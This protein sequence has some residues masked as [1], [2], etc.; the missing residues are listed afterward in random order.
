MGVLKVYR[1]QLIVMETP[2]FA[3]EV[4]A[5]AAKSNESL[6]SL[7]RQ[8]FELGWFEVKR[9]LV[10]RFG[11]ISPAERLVGEVGSILPTTDRKVYAKIR[12]KELL[13]TDADRREY[14]RLSR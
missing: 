14:A 13:V 12:G 9:D 6:S 5:Y 8:S 10:E 7:L 1:S 11:V 3:G 2:E 4:R